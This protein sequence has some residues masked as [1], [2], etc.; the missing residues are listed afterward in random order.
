VVSGG[1]TITAGAATISVGPESIGHLSRA[2][3]LLRGVRVLATTP[4]D[5]GVACHFL[6]AWTL[7]S[8]LKSYLSH[9]G[10]TKKQ[11]NPIR[12]NLE[13][14]WEKAASNGFSIAARPPDWCKLLNSIHGEPYHSRYPTSWAGYVG[15]G[16]GLMTSELEAVFAAVEK[17]VQP[18]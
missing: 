17:V 4:S 8:L 15:P 16:L 5:T 9:C 1:G 13:A 14:L 12:H 3:G 6:A 10:V 7:E 2:R 18:G 11:L